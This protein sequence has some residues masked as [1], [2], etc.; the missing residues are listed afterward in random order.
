MADS[1]TN[2]ITVS[3]QPQ[4]A[5]QIASGIY[6]KNCGQPG[7]GWFRK[8]TPSKWLRSGRATVSAFT[9]I[10]GVFFRI[11]EGMRGGDGRVGAGE[12]SPESSFDLTQALKGALATLSLLLWIQGGKRW[13]LRGGWSWRAQAHAADLE[14]LLEAVGLEEVGEFEGADIAALGADFTLEVK[15]DGAQVRQRVAGP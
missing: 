14:I 12:L 6:A 10:E 7:L 4:C 13:W 8:A 9:I 11:N 3:D 1:H 15:D 5:G 2:E